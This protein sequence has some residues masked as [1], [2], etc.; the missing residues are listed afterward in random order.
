MA[1]K[2]VGATATYHHGDLR[3]ALITVGTQMLE[4][5]GPKELSLR[6]LARMVGVYEAAPSRH[7]SGKDELLAAIGT[8]GFRSLA[9][10][11]K[12]IAG[13]GANAHWTLLQMLKWYVKYAQTHP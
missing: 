5:I 10:Q 4:D 7:F 8:E 1:K 3:N 2:T 9:E 6:H 13:A 11:G 12:R